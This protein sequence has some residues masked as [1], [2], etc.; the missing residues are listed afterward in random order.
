MNCQLLPAV[1]V[2][3]SGDINVMG[4]VDAAM[5]EA[6]GSITVNG[7]I[8]GHGAVRD[9]KGAIRMD[10]GYVTANAAYKTLM[11]ESI[12][13][14]TDMGRPGY[15]SIT[16]QTNDSGTKVIYGQAWVDVNKDNLDDW[17]TASG[18]YML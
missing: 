1:K 18:D 11:G 15:E 10:A 4:T 14:G 17:K 9:D 13:A 6:E 7:G 16:I 12:V 3:A 8:I 5:L 2:K